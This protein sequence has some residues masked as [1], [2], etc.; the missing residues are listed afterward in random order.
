M[1][2]LVELYCDVDDFCK[3]FIPQWQQQLLQDGT[4]NVN[5]MGT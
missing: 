3:I 5:E 2:K 1:N 4:Q